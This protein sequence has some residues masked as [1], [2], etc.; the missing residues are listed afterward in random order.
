M[1]R[2]YRGGWKDNRLH[3]AGTILDEDNGLVLFEGT[4]KCGK[5]QG[6]GK[7]FSPLKMKQSAAV[8]GVRKE[9]RKPTL[10]FRGDFVEDKKTGHGTYF[11]EEDGLLQYSGA[12]LNG[13]YHGLG[14][15]Y[16]RAR[17]KKKDDKTDD[18][19]GCPHQREY[20]GPF[21]RGAYHGH[22][23]QLF[24]RQGR[25]LHS[26]SFRDGKRHGYG[27]AFHQPRSAT[28]RNST[29]PQH[30]SFVGRFEGR[31]KSVH[32]GL[33]VPHAGGGTLLLRDGRRFVGDFFDGATDPL[34]DATMFFPHDMWATPGAILPRLAYGRFDKTSVAWVAQH[35]QEPKG[36][37]WR[38]RGHLDYKDGSFYRGPFR[39]GRPHG[40]AGLLTQRNLNQ[41]QGR[42]N[43]GRCRPSTFSRLVVR[44]G[45]AL[46]LSFYEYPSHIPNPPAA[47]READRYCEF[48]DAHNFEI[49]REDNLN[50]LAVEHLLLEAQLHLNGR[51]QSHPD[52]PH[53]CLWV[54]TTGFAR[55]PGTCVTTGDL[56]EL[57]FF[58]DY[59]GDQVIPHLRAFPKFYVTQ[60]SH[61]PRETR[62]WSDKP[63]AEEWN[64]HH[65]IKLIATRTGETTWD[66]NDPG[67]KTVG[68]ACATLTAAMA[69]AEASGLGGDMAG[70]DV[71]KAW[72]EPVE[73][74]VD[75]LHPFE[76][77]AA[78]ISHE[79]GESSLP[80]IQFLPAARLAAQDTKLLHASVRA[81]AAA[82][83][84]EAMVGAM[85]LVARKHH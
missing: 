81:M 9:K 17:I 4:F 31:L 14:T 67:A 70:I 1:R 23:G 10:V 7:Q 25:L 52:A 83:A 40:K 57:P 73:T 54:V 62:G 68:H 63:R 78:S 20:V 3:G 74:F 41:H 58:E 72:L 27:R 2:W 64:S 82:I 47:E 13:E 66:E 8:T 60:C 35:G 59:L 21:R 77:V 55:R 24:T 11:Y 26:G 65:V 44:R 36:Q 32:R 38:G 28:E 61:A 33:G 56:K 76:T 15:T 50:K 6:V 5:R 79:P 43:M 46:V 39:D 80:R 19:D 75:T 69:A 85:E 51:A 12:L 42:W 22:G 84:G 34:H 48:L 71:A 29:W 30:C 49:W 16:F 53:D 18:C 37:V 45:F